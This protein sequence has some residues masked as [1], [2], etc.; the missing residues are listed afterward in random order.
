MIR[1]Q[2]MHENHGHQ[3]NSNSSENALPRAVER[4]VLNGI[5]SILCTIPAWF[6]QLLRARTQIAWLTPCPLPTF[7]PQREVRRQGECLGL[8]PVVMR[9]A[10]TWATSMLHRCR[11]TGCT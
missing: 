5:L 7:L 3:K 4:I 9:A 11:Q 8:M 6:S 2:P 1:M 10:M